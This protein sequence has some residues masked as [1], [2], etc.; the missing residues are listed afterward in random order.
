MSTFTLQK[1]K[2]L[3]M[4]YIAMFSVLIA[5]CSWICIPTTVPFTM[6]TFGVFVTVGVLGGRRGS[7]SILVYLLLGAIGVPVFAGCTGGIGILLGN[8]GG[9]NL[10][11][12]LAALFMWGMEKVV[13]QRKWVLTLS[14]LLGLL[15]CYAFGTTW[16]MV[17]Y[18]GSSGEIGLLTALGWCVFP[19]VLPDFVKMA[20]ALLV[21]NKIK[22]V[23]H[24]N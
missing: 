1:S 19:F 17:I 2:T 22:K 7:L 6:Q 23:I 21:C 9:Y 20:L 3:D 5:I 10:G 13:G 16:F 14:M 18:A 12:L 11:F 8:T 15:I 4:V 24:V